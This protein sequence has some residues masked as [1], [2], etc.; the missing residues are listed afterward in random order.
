MR[1]YGTPY[2]K[3]IW[4]SKECYGENMEVFEQLMSPEWQ[5]CSSPSDENIVHICSTRDPGVIPIRIKPKDG[6]RE[7]SFMVKI[8]R[9]STEVF[10][11]FFSSNETA[12]QESSDLNY[13]KEHC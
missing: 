11:N 4:E 3:R 5:L 6:V 2:A 13:Y 1:D 9:K 10:T 7:D 8:R 12:T